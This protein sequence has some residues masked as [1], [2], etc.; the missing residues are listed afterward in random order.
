M[1]PRMPRRSDEIPTR[2]L[3]GRLEVSIITSTHRGEA[4]ARSR[5][6]MAVAT[7]RGLVFDLIRSRGPISRVVLA[8]STGLTQATMSY[9]VRELI[10]D[11]LVIETGHG[12]STGGKRPTLLD[13]DPAARFAVGV[14]LGADEITY[15]VTNL[16]GA[17]IGRTRT[18]GPTDDPEQ[19]VTQIAD[20]IAELLENVGVRRDR[21]VGLGIVAPGPLDLASGTIFAPP[22]M[23]AWQQFP[24]RSRLAQATGLPVL[25]DNDAT[26]AAVAEFWGGTLADSKA[27]MTVYMGAGIGAG[28]VLGGTVFR[29]AS[30]NTGELGQALHRSASASGSGSS[31]G[32]AS[33]DEW[34]TV[35]DVAAPAA[36]AARARAAITSGTLTGIELTADANPYRDFALVALAATRGNAEALALIAESAEALAGAVVSA[37]NILDLD[38]VV[39]AGPSF[40][41]AGSLYVR[42]LKRKLDARFFAGDLH[43]VQVRLSGQ[44]AE[45]AAVGGAALVLQ[46]TLSPRSFT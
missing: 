30:G 5:S 27:H 36:V 37:A 22:T 41:T 31:A 1:R 21:V 13:I 23:T 34:V 24:L 14:Q 43:D 11:G 9:V 25:L 28:I 17:I 3:D 33:E 29:G 45:A 12:E 32:S 26:A 2:C 46:N 10:E 44:V 19:V 38:S 39:L 4:P 15:V 18:H 20:R 6:S 7:S 8:A 16:G 35:E 40:A 42:V